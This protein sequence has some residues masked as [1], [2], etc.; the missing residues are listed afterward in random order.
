MSASRG[1]T[2]PIKEVLMS[3]LRRFA[4]P[5]FGTLLFWLATS[6]PALAQTHC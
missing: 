2:S 3:D 5:V 4:L 1:A 6:A